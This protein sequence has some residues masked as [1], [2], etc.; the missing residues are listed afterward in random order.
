[1]PEQVYRQQFISCTYNGVVLQGLGEGGSF[2]LRHRG[3]EV[4]LT[5]GTDGGD[6]NLATD[7]GLQADVTLRETATTHEF[8]WAQHRSQGAGA[9]GATLV[10]LTGTGRTISMPE[11]YVGMPGELTT[12]DKRQGSH[13]YTFLSNRPTFY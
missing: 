9:P 13:T 3:G 10:I 2:L 7:Q 12:G 8:L 4:E 5:E 6:I 1:M 11:A